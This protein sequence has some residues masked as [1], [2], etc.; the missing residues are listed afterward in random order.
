L[1]EALATDRE[2]LDEGVTPASEAGFVDA[3]DGEFV[4]NQEVTA[5]APPKKME[6]S[7][8]DMLID[9]IERICRPNPEMNLYKLT[10]IFDSGVD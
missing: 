10:L 3:D 5:G 6:L 7:D 4:R 8:I 2:L 1:V 9:E